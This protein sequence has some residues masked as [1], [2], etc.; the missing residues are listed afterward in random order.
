MVMAPGAFVALGMILAGMNAFNRWQSRRKGEIA[1]VSQNSTCAS[2]GAC[3]ACDG[4]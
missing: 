3:N 1:P 4:K 2:C